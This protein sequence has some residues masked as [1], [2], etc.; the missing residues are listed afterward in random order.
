M[1]V[2]A[3]VDGMAGVVLADAV[4]GVR[5]SFRKVADGGGWMEEARGERAMFPLLR[6]ATAV[7]PPLA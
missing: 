4:R 1:G 6:P 7:N 3:E 2:L 5:E